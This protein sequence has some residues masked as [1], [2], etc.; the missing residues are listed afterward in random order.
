MKSEIIAVASKS[1]RRLLMLVVMLH[2]CA[3]A[4]VSLFLCSV[5]AQGVQ[6]GKASFYSK[7][8]TGSRTANGERLHHDSLTCAHRSYPFGTLLRV[9][10]V[11]NNKQVIVRVNDRGPYRRGRIIDLSWGAAKAIGMISQGVTQVIVERLPQATIPYKLVEQPDSLPIF[12][13]DIAEISSG[14][15][16]VWQLDK[17]ATKID[18][19][20]VQREMKRTAEEMKAQPAPTNTQH[21]TPTTKHQTPTTQHPEKDELDEINNSPNRSRAYQKRNQGNLK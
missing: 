16:P 15:T 19:R 13:F 17:S 1:G 12:E 8:A 11:L 21:Q 18:E 5:F 2:I 9:T 3:V 10:N 14:T 4:N 6:S 20:K 7:R